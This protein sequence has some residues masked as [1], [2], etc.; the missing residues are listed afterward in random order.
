MGAKI[1]LKIGAEILLYGLIILSVVLFTKSRA[2]SQK[3]GDFKVSI[4]NQLGNYFINEEEIVNLI[5]EK[6]KKSIIGEELDQLDLRSMEQLI[7]QLDFVNDAQVYKDL[8]NNLR[9]EI[10]QNR[11][12]A[13]LNFKDKKGDYL[14]EDGNLLPLSSRFTARVPLISGPY[15]EQLIKGDFLK[16][17]KGKSFIDF[18]KMID[19]D[20]FWSAQLAYFDVDREGKI[21][22]Y[23]QVGKQ[24][25][26]FGTIENVKEKLSKLKIFY[27]KILPKAGWNKYYRVNLEYH[28]QIICE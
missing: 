9:I 20:E 2:G 12:I 1:K 17:E 27:K 28:N 23:P 3:T 6:G 26:E 21:S 25:I 4:D 22:I 10:V 8:K 24:V 5:T 14:D 11:P 7:E 16:T 13:R 15:A 19:K 18:F